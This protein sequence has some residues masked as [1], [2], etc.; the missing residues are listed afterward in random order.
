MSYEGPSFLNA[1]GEK[2]PSFF[3]RETQPKQAGR[4]SFFEDIEVERKPLERKEKLLK[5]LNSVKKEK[6]SV[7]DSYLDGMGSIRTSTPFKPKELP[8]SELFHA[9]ANRQR[10]EKALLKWMKPRLAIAEEDLLLFEEYVDH[11]EERT[12]VIER[13]RGGLKRSLRSIIE[14]EKA[15]MNKQTHQP[16]LFRDKL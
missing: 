14:E 16:P 13:K 3:E 1:R 8:S 5:P 9:F 7:K 2:A 12:E 15:A 4:R 10:Y 6:K 11:V